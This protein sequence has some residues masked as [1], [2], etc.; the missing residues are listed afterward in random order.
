MQA[1]TPNIIVFPWLWLSATD[2]VEE[3]V[4]RDFYT[5][6]RLGDY[7]KPWY[8]GHDD[9][10]GVEYKC[11]QMFT[12]TPPD[13]A[14]GEG[15][16]DGYDKGCPCQYRQQPILLLR[17]LCQHSALKT[18]NGE[19]GTQ[20]TPK[21]LAESPNEVFHMGGVSTRIH[22]IDSIKQWV[23][24]DAASSVRAESRASKLS[25]VLGKHEWT[26]T[27]DVFSCSEGQ[28][29]TTLLKLSGCDPEG[30]FTCSDG[31]CITMAQRCNQISNCKD[32]SDEVDCK[33]I[34]FENN[35]NNK[36]PPIV[37]I[38]DEDDFKPAQLNISIDLL[39]IVDM[40]ETDHKIDFQFRIT[41]EWRENRVVYNNLKRDTSLNA[42]SDED[43][44]S[45]WLPSI[46]YDNTDQKEMT[47]LGESWEWVTP[48]SVM[49]EGNF[50]S[51]EKNPGCRRSGIDEVDEIEIF[52]GVSNR[53]IMKQVY[54]WQF[55][56]LYQLKHYPFDV[57]V[58]E[59]VK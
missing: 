30:D 35:Y 13:I 27:N 22:Y 32:K 24:T 48:I 58:R 41:L 10:Y 29:Y 26:V 40:E 54:T 31:Q 1:I 42:L 34:I 39:R 16:C 51:C 52:E 59:G 14:W 46:I 45:L 50:S 33:L 18:A 7:K 55:Q 3:G 53:I 9:K 28:P 25:Y 6:E 5:G 21:Q 4:W 23:I 20:Y 56:C 47:R 15:Q 19:L 57:Q 12:D 49:K 44:R 43:A 2:Q 38:I 36:I 37:P 11:L 8:P 17:G